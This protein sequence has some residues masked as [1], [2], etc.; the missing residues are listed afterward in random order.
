MK[1]KG[2]EILLP[3]KSF[4][5]YNH[6]DYAAPSLKEIQDHSVELITQL[7]Q[8]ASMMAS[9]NQKIPILSIFI[10]WSATISLST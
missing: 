5:S 3:L 1:D 9:K 2:I 6:T 7:W 8:A 10:A 4:T